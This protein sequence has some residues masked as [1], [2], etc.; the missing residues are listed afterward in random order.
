MCEC[1]F[2][3]KHFI[4]ALTLRIMHKTK[5]APEKCLSSVMYKCFLYYQTDQNHDLFHM[6]VSPVFGDA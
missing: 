2:L 6:T 3:I 5:T 1:S 4:Q